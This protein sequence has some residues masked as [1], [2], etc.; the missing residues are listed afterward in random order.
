MF[1]LKRVPTKLNYITKRNL[2]WKNLTED[3]SNKINNITDT[4]NELTAQSTMIMLDK[5][6]RTMKLTEE[7]LREQKL[8]GTVITVSLTLGPVQLSISDTVTETQLD[9]E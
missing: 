6:I 7:R 8:Y 5:S 9:K 2:N 4:A 1:I 3:A